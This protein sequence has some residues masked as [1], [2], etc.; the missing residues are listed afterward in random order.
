MKLVAATETYEQ[1][2]DSWGPAG[3]LG[4]DLTLEVMDAGGGPYVVIST[5][6]W[7]LDADDIDAF[8]SRIR[9]LLDRVEKEVDTH[10]VM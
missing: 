4:Q 8:V 2:Q 9:A 1:E 10:P 3:H 6:R 7:A 5:P